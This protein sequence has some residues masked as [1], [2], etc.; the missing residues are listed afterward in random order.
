MSWWRGGFLILAIHPA[1][2]GAKLIRPGKRQASLAFSIAHPLRC[3]RFAGSVFI[4]HCQTPD[5]KKAQAAD[6]RLGF[7]NA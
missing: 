7:K 3:W 2:I 1:A 4:S 5:K 6:G